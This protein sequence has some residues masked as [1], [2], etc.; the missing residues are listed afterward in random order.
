LLHRQS[1]LADCHDVNCVSYPQDEAHSYDQLAAAA[2][3]RLGQH[4]PGVLLAESFGGAV[5]LT[6][7][8]TAPALVRRMVLVNTFA[9]FPRRPLI[10][11]AAL[12]GRG[13]PHRPSP[14]S[15]RGLR[16]LFFFGPDIPPGLRT[17]W[18]ERTA[19]V[20]LSAYGHRLGM[21]AALDLR[22]RLS[23]IAI[24]TLV[25]VAPNDRVVP[26][27]AGRALARRLPRARLLEVRAGHAAMIH[28]DV[29]IGRLLADAALW[30]S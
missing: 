20:P 29:N 30:A 5:A 14:S 16:G 22:A 25:I 23:E 13:F 1:G 17:E 4:G 27:S 3:Q 21:V 10:R 7:A 28:P 19:D 12:V 2:I 15:A 8:L 24:P 9:Y 6:V 18:W 11:L 26:P